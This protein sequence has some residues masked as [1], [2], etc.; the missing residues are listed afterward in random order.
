MYRVPPVYPSVF[1]LCLFT[2]KV[3]VQL[4]EWI[5]ILQ[6]KNTRRTEKHGTNRHGKRRKRLNLIKVE[7]NPW[8]LAD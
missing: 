5:K 3:S 1:S 8:I 2:S 6:K 7:V 4:I